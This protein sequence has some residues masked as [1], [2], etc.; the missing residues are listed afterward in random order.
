MLRTDILASSKKL[1]RKR[2]ASRAGLFVGCFL[3][4]FVGISALFYIPKFRIQKISIQGNAVLK[5]E[6][7]IFNVLSSL[8]GKYF[9]ILPRDNVFILPKAEVSSNLLAGFSRV[10]SVH[11]E[12]DFPKSLSVAI[13]E[14]KPIALHCQ[15]DEEKTSCGFVDED[16]VIFEDAP[17]FSDNVYV[18]FYNENGGKIEKIEWFDE[19]LNF[20]KLVSSNNIKIRK[21]V[22]E[23]GGARKFYTSEGWYILINENDDI[24]AVFGNLRLALEKQIKNNRRNLGYIDL[25]FGNKIYYKFK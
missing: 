10:K 14:R 11:L 15:D 6:E 22:L 13:V 7:I 4:L 5:N 23:K 20:S 18:K 2:I 8:N 16:G 19:M 3:V 25:R 12:K 24:E 17:A 21:V 9:G 1:K